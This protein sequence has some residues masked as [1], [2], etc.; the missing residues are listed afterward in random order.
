MLSM[1]ETIAAALLFLAVLT[2]FVFDYS[3]G[4]KYTVQK[5]E[6]YAATLYD[7]AKL[8]QVIYGAV[9]SLSNVSQIGSLLDSTGLG[10][11]SISVISL[12][13]S[14]SHP[15][16]QICRALNRVVDVSARLYLVS[17]CV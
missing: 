3:T 10:N 2:V 1:I 9:P 11:Y 6:W 15:S 17:V 7:S 13:G 12:N 16:D 4:I 14:A 8:Q 5:Y